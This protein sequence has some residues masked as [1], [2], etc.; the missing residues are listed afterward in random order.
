MN[1]LFIAKIVVVNEVNVVV[2]GNDCLARIITQNKIIS[3]S[4]NNE[5]KR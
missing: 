1:T 4:P 3:I 5:R 2:L